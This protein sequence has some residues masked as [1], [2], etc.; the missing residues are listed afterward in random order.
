M[1][2]C[3]FLLEI[4]FYTAHTHGRAG[5]IEDFRERRNECVACPRDLNALA[6]MVGWLVGETR[7]NPS[8]VYTTVNCDCVNWLC[9]VQW[10]AFGR[11]KKKEKTPKN[12][13]RN[14]IPFGCIWDKLW[15]RGAWWF[16][17]Y[18]WLGDMLHF[19]IRLSGSKLGIRWSVGGHCYVFE[20]KIRVDFS[21]ANW[22]PTTLR[23]VFLMPTYGLEELRQFGHVY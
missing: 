16:F 17:F 15:I 19:R 11:W 18:R 6:G 23:I 1:E 22:C 9:V 5:R 10:S 20:I 3:V 14:K 7:P 21:Y 13:G 4:S 12:K 2:D 8:L